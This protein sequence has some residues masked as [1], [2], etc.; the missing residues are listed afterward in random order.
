MCKD[1]QM[2]IYVQNKL[3]NDELKMSSG[4]K[5]TIREALLRSRARYFQKNTG[6][7]GWLKT[8]IQL[9]NAKIVIKVLQNCEITLFLL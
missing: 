6:M 4:Q 1:M 7:L 5:K 2:Q 8:D 3:K 9:N